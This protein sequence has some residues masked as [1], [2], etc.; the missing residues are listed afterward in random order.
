MPDPNNIALRESGIVLMLL[1]KIANTSIKVALAKAYKI[2]GVENIHDRGLFE[3]VSKREAQSFPIRIAI[4]RD[5]LDRLVSCFRDKFL[6]ATNEDF[7]AGFRRRGWTPGMTFEAFV[8]AVAELPDT[9]CR[10]VLQHIRSMSADLVSNEKII[11]NII[12]RF[13]SLREEWQVLQ[14]LLEATGG[15]FLPALSHER[16]SLS[17]APNYDA[18]RRAFARQRYRDDIRFFGYRAP[19]HFEIDPDNIT[20]GRSICN[21]HREAYCLVRDRVADPEI[22]TYLMDLLAEAFDMGKR[23][24]RALDRS[25]YLASAEFE[26]LEVA[27]K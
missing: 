16:R 19:R 1:P 2:D 7:L 11:P 9:D 14:A 15:P 5:P 13:E 22:A 3:Y 17:P 25:Q 24:N 23:M 27:R 20:V 8:E 21:V 12:F 4:V 18:R 6:G 10:G 26:P